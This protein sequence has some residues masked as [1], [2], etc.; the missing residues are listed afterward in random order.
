MGLQIQILLDN[1]T[2]SYY[3]GET[4]FGRIVVVND[5]FRKAKGLKLKFT[6]KCEVR[7]SETKTRQVRNHQDEVVNESHTIHHYAEE[8]YLEYLLN[9]FGNDGSDPTIPPEIPR[10]WA[11]DVKTI[12]EFRI[13]GAVDLDIN[14]QAQ[15]EGLIRKQKSFGCCCCTSG[16]ATYVLK[17]AKSGAYVGEYIPFTLEINNHSSKTLGA[18]V[19]LIQ[20]VIFNAQ[21]Q[22]RKIDTVMCSVD[23]PSVSPGDDDVWRGNVLQVPP[24][25]PSGLGGVSSLIEVRYDLKMEMTGVFFPLQGKTPIIIGTRPHFNSGGANQFSYEAPPPYNPTI[26]VGNYQADASAPYQQSPPQVNASAPYLQ[27]PL[28]V[29]ASVPYSQAPPQLNISAPY[30]RAPLQMNASAAYSQAPPQLNISAPYPQAPLQE[31]LRAPYQHLPPHATPAVPLNQ[32][33]IGFHAEGMFAKNI[34]PGN[35]Q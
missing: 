23:G 26:P 6:G 15:Q 29:N 11:F 24:C 4:V 17:L 34:H 5:D 10:S 32:N 21:G 1:S 13:L 19:S 27:A 12:T 18:R 22:Q 7:F 3:P 30:P 20:K 33:T 28:Q 31:N 16:D 35:Y 8:T 2:N 9:V 25:V 14:G